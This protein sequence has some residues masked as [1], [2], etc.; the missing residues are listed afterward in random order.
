MP[1]F[2]PSRPMPDSFTPPNGATSVEMMPTLMPTMPDSS[3]FGDAPDAADVAAV[4]VRGE[5]E[6]GVVRE[7]DRLVLGLEADTA[8]RPGRRSPRA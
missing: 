7:L 2:E 3:A 8:A 6:L 4:E 5:A 1:Y